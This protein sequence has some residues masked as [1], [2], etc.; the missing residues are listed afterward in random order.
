MMQRHYVYLKSHRLVTSLCA[1]VLEH[2]EQIPPIN[3]Y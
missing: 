1:D 2:M 3:S